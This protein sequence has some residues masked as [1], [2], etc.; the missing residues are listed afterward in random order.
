[1]TIPALRVIR[2]L[3]VASG[4]VLAVAGMLTLSLPLMVAGAVLWLL[5]IVLE[6]GATGR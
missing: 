5:G 1:V 4:L 3:T 2:F 6:E